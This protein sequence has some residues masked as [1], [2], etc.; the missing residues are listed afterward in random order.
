MTNTHQLVNRKN[1]PEELTWDLTA[2]YPNDIAFQTDIDLV[3]DLVQA[4]DTAYHGHLDKLVSIH[5]A[6]SALED[7]YTRLSHIEH[8]AFLQQAVDITDATANQLMREFE[9]LSAEISTKLV[10]FDIELLEL[11]V[12]RLDEVVVANPK[13]KA[14]IRQL[15][16]QKEYQLSPEVE[17]VLATFQPNFSAPES[18][19]GQTRAADMDFDD[20]E[21]NGV[22]YPMSF[23]L[24]ENTYQYNSDP[25]VRHAAFKSFSTTLAHYKHTI[26]A[27]YYNQVSMEKRIATLRGY[28]SVFDY[29]L[30][31]QEVDRTLFNRQIDTIMTKLAPV[32]QKYAAHIK[33]VRGLDKMTFADLQI[34][35]D[36]E[37]APKVSIE[38]AKKYVNDAVAPL[39]SDYQA[40]VARS[41]PERWID[42]PQN[43]GKETGG[44]ET[45]P[46]GK[47][48]YIL[49]SWTDELADVYTLIHELGHA[50]QAIL[51]QDNQSILGSEPST[52]LVEAPST[53]NELLLTTSIENQ[54]MEPRLQRFA[55][56]KMLTNTY[57]H[58]FVTH[59]LE[60]AY[61]RE[62]YQL[63][64]AGQGFDGDQLSELKRNVLERFWGPDVEINDGAELTWMRQSHYYMGLYS[65]TYSAGLAISTQAHLNL[66]KDPEVATESWLAFLKLGGEL[67]PIEAAKVAGVD[68]TTDE[69]LNQTIQFLDETVDK[70]IALSQTI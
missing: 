12:E 55:Y 14:Y 62:V 69:P 29:L 18:V 42:F 54:S 44:F 41:F 47:H 46:Y 26:A 63:I 23:V 49:M 68:I 31:E 36:P 50:G 30:A 5:D 16:K 67:P 19:Y 58:N 4:F 9:A 17:Q 21:V 38:D 60:A 13:L 11:P 57:F 20:F 65:Y 51:T 6:F 7:I 37:F 43:I 25:A 66:L 45:T 56:S 52:Y 35:L 28:D 32:M 48:P 40:M 39:G 15:K 64:D 2:I 10:F 70:I 61:Q 34:D 8:Y 3:R 33:E 27:N 22:T 24:Y 53:F 59:L 1:V